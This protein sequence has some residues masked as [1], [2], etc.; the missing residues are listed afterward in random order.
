[1]PL[2]FVVA[3]WADSRYVTEDH[4]PNPLN[5]PDKK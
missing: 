3:S 1:M 5:F 2:L 4:M